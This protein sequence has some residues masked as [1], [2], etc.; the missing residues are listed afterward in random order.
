M[1]S[2]SGPAKLSIRAPE[3]SLSAVLGLVEFPLVASREAA[4]SLASL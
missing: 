4:G 3:M 1:S 2:E